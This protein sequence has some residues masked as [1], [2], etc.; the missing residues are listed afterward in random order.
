MRVVPTLQSFA[1]VPQTGE[2]SVTPGNATFGIDFVD[3]RILHL[4]LKGVAA[5]LAPQQYFSV[6]PRDGAIENEI[7]DTIA[8]Y[9]MYYDKNMVIFDYS[10][11][12]EFSMRN[13]KE[14]YFTYNHPNNEQIAWMLKNVFS[15]LGHEI[16]IDLNGA[17][18]LLG[19]FR[20]PSLIGPK[21]QN[22]SILDREIGIEAATRMFY[23]YFDQMDKQALI[24][25]LHKS[26]YFKLMRV[27]F[28]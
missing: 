27:D 25:E 2:W 23:I 20:F 28:I 26:T 12:Y 8:K 24:D 19:Q 14:C 4:Y 1:S 3:F 22:H 18:E 13:G 5:E 6:S 7:A 11:M 15:E 9:K 17:Y 16:N 10:K 21:K